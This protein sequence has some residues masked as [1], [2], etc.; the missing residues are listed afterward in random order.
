MKTQ[1]SAKSYDSLLSKM[2][3]GK[4]CNIITK[5]SQVSEDSKQS[6]VNPQEKYKYRKQIN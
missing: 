3:A 5:I 2:L 4:T 6:S 1:K